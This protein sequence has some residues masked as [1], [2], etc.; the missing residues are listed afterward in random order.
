[1][2]SQFSKHIGHTISDYANI[3]DNKTQ[4]IQESTTG[5]SGMP[6]DEPG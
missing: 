1:M 6:H 3:I 2:A 4:S 5:D